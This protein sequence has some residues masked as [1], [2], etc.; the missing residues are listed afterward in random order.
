MASMLIVECDNCKA[1]VVSDRHSIRIE[2]GSLRNRRPEIDFCA[3]CFSRW[4][5]A[6]DEKQSEPQPQEIGS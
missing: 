4:L 5:E 6:I 2:S 1:K 3:S